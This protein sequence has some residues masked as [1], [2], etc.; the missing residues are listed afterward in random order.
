[1][2]E[3][4]IPQPRPLENIMLRRQSTGWQSNTNP[5]STAPHEVAG[6]PF[7]IIGLRGIVPLMEAPLSK[8]DDQWRELLSEEQ[9]LIARKKGTERA[10][11]GAY[12]DHKAHGTYHCICCHEPLFSSQSKY[13]SGSGWPSFWQAIHKEAIAEET[14]SQYGM[15]RTEILCSRCHAHLGHVFEDGPQPTGLRFCVNS[16]CLSFEANP[17]ESVDSES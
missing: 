9:F 1:M 3:S 11:T 17:Q 12:W 4:G 6:A 13:D 10:F 2:G 14:D 15:I 7:T 16:A 8:T 5:F